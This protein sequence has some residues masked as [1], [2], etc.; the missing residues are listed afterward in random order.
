MLVQFSVANYRSFG[1]EQT[2]SLVA[3][4]RL[5]GAH[6][7]HAVP[8]PDSTERVL[9]AAVL[10]GAN[11][12]GK[13]NLFKA[14]RFFSRMAVQTRKGSG[15]GRTPFQFSKSVT[16]PSSFDIQMIAGGRLY[17]YGIKVDD[18]RVIEEWLVQVI[19]G[20][21]REIFE[22]ATDQD[23]NTLIEAPDFKAKKDDK[24]GLLTAIGAVHNQ[25][26]LATARATI[27]R[28]LPEDIQNVIGWFVQSL[29]LTG[30]SET[31]E[32][33]GHML[34]SSS[35]FLAFA[36]QFLNQSATGVDHLKVDKIEATEDELSRFLPKSL[37]SKVLEDLK[38]GADDDVAVVQMPDGSELIVEKKDANHFYRVG[39]QALHQGEAGKLTPLPLREESDGTRRLLQLLP[40]LHIA[41]TGKAVYFIDE[42]DRSMHPMLVWKFLEFFLHSC[43][44]GTAQIIVTTHES[45]LLDLELLR[46]DEIW[47]AEKGQ[48]LQTKIYPL[49]DYA[50]RKDL[51]IRKHY[52]QGRFGAV[53]F[54]SGLD[55]LL[56]GSE[57]KCH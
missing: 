28:D 24:F 54:L 1:E 34:T 48:D 43:E 53:P 26:F 32:P 46:R 21:E 33:V 42:I 6:E 37:L 56:S 40:A 7:E 19:G 9:R 49:T 41:K 47:F 20:R 10:Y 5:T 16:A 57:A 51:E 50:V 27:E 18:T 44:A 12:A 31:I 35:D 29:R 52:L 55:R 13:S 22:R 17:R 25:T 23:N 14:L 11:G 4:N 30:P 15:T 39:I 8:I 45:N 38:S 2:F 36:G 3:S